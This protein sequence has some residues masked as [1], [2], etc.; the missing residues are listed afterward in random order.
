MLPALAPVEAA[1]VI[2]FTH[3]LP[4]F[5]RCRRFVIMTGAAIDPFVWL[6]GLDDAQPSFLA[7]DPT[8]VA[9][10]YALPLSVA[11]RR[12]LDA[13]EGEP[14]LWLALVKVDEAEATVNLR[15]PVVVNPRRMLGLQIVAADSPY[16]SAHPLSG[17]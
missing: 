15:A 14:L 10:E 1:G 16:P 11:D 13:S 5:E 12:R 6:N 4:G 17:Q 9:P 8:L 2:T 3:G 7:V